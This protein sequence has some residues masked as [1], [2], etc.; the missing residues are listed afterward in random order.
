[1]FRSEAHDLESLAALVAL[2]L[3]IEATDAQGFSA[4]DYAVLGKSQSIQSDDDV[5]KRQ[6]TIDA[7]L[8]LLPS[9]GALSH[10]LRL[11]GELQVGRSRRIVQDGKEHEIRDR[12]P[13]SLTPLL[14]QLVKAGAAVEEAI[15]YRPGSRRR[16][17][18]MTMLTASAASRG[19]ATAYGFWYPPHD[20]IIWLLREYARDLLAQVDSKGRS[21]IHYVCDFEGLDLLIPTPGSAIL[22]NALLEYGADP[23]ARDN[24]GNT[25]LH[26][27]VMNACRLPGEVG[28]YPEPCAYFASPTCM[29]CKRVAEALVARGAKS[30]LKNYRGVTARDEA[31]RRNRCPLPL[32]SALA[33]ADEPIEGA[34]SSDGW[35]DK[36]DGIESAEEE[37]DDERVALWH[38]EDVPLVAHSESEAPCEQPAQANEA[39]AEDPEASRLH[40]QALALYRAANTLYQ[41]Y[42]SHKLPYIRIN[43]NNGRR[44]PVRQAQ[45]Y[46]AYIFHAFYGG[47]KA[48]RANQPGKSKHE[49]GFA[50]DVVRNI[51]A[52]RLSRALTA[53][54]WT[55]PVDDEGWHWEASDAQKY[56]ALASYIDKEMA[57]LSHEFGL[58]LSSY[59]E[60]RRESLE[61]I[62]DVEALRVSVSQFERRHDE[63]RVALDTERSAIQ[64]EGERLA[65]VMSQARDA[66][67][68]LARLE[69]Q[70]RNKR[71]TYCPNGNTYEACQHPDLKARYDREVRELDGAIV[72]TRARQAALTAEH[73]RGVAALEQRQR[74]C[75]SRE[76][77]WRS[78]SRELQKLQGELRTKERQ[79][80]R[81]KQA[82]QNARRS[83]SE[84]LT[85]IAAAVQRWA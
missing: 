35:I 39:L 26:L 5:E 18:L 17:L 52:M 65:T 50:M 67:V 13:V 51:D 54:G 58:R 46:E 34:D 44:S 36:R 85:L 38:D 75:D 53:S 57:P 63:E 6:R 41:S 84:Q 11:V 69:T 28:P 47:P 12:T 79:L 33:G 62:G 30:S 2:G 48:P 72:R 15:E 24:D 73:E 16:N 43:P 64:R 37:R 29:E 49:Y 78:A 40:P 55:Q 9:I 7:L 56:Q 61:L 21:I 10:A 83:G 4:L 60:R 14:I 20:E 59:Y 25:P 82:M 81:A 8:A 77:K 74:D 27:L 31:F 66:G 71:Y 1:M 45:L 76:A 42:D 32:G 22:A 70:R 19:P 23:N 3:A 80:T 68:E